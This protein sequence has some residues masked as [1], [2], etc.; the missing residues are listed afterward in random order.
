M[1]GI[2]WDEF[3]I[4]FVVIVLFLDL[5]GV[6]FFLLRMELKLLRKIINILERVK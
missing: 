6:G 5:Y 3:I 1:S 4:W 2:K